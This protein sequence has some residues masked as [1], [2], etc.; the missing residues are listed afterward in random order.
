MCELGTLQSVDLR[1][2]WP[3]EA[4]DFTPWLAEEENLARLAETLNMELELEAQEIDVGNFR[5]DLLCRNTED[6]S[7]VLIENQLAQ[8]DHKHLGQ[9]L[10]YAPGLN[11][12]T[13]VWIAEEFREE[14][15]AALDWQNEITAEHF[16]F[17]GVEIRLWRIGESPPAP[18][19][20]I[21][22]KPNNWSRTV[23]R[24]V[25]RASEDNL[26][27]TQLLQ[28]RFW[29]AFVEYLA[30]RRSSISPPNPQPRADMV[31]GSIVKGDFKRVASL[32][33]TAKQIRV[34]LTIL[35]KNATAYFHLLEEKRAEIESELGELEWNEK[36]DK[37]SSSIAVYRNDTDVTDDAEWPNQHEWLECKLKEFR[38]VFGPRIQDLDAADWQ[39]EDEDDN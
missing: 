37:K 3:N 26:S 25:Q 23:S 24:D 14:H 2:I 13:I 31:L 16:Q 10:T 9:I 1:C 36:P 15:R 32:L 30:D 4:Q 19:F 33:K 27:E 8:T 20:N 22:S 7:R 29:A 12:A 5:A 6:N 35:N 21:V 18:Q 39:P 11:V 17:F 28:R 34:Q 38:E